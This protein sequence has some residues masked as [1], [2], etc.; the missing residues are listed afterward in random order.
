MK[1]AL[2]TGI[3]GQDGAYIAEY[4]LN[5]GY[6]V[7]GLIRRL[8]ARNIER[9]NY[10]KIAGDV[11]LIDGD[12]TDLS[13]II[14]VLKK[15]KPDEVYNLAAQS[16][17]GTS[18]QQPI[19]TSDVTAIGALNVLESIRLTDPSIKFYQASTSEMFGK[20][21]E[22]VQCEN[23]PFHPRSPYGVSKLYA[24]WMT[25][26]YRES[27]NMFACS[28]ILFNHESPIRGLEFVTRK[29]TNSAVRIKLGLQDKLYL[30]NIDAKRDWG[31]AKD[32]VKAMYLMLQHDKPEDFVIATGRTSSVRDMCKIA[33]DYLGLNYEDYVKIDKN[34]FRPAEVE[35]LIGKPVKAEKYLGWKAE[36]TLE[37]MIKEMVDADMKRVKG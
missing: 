9:L 35:I 16:F 30:G 32:Y 29:V 37:D 13:S 4:L 5:K 2:I 8:S 12:I 17:V 18:W 10:L 1:T 28:G 36:I 26:N 22:M 14:R 19:L 15:D 34:L 6:N 20:I 25:V 27:F 21:K 33:F 31:H 7:L 23:T 3:T 11:K 24:H